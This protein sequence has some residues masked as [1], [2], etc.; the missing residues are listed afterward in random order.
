MVTGIGEIAV[1][2]LIAAVLV[3][4]AKLLKQPT[5]LA[6]LVAGVVIGIFGFFHFDRGDI[7]NVFSDLGIMFLLFLVGLEINYTSL[8][9][10]GKTSLII[11]LGQI[12]FTSFFGFIISRVLG[13][14]G[15]E[16][17]YIAIG[18][19]FSSTIIII[20]LLSA[21]DALNSLYGKISIG[22]LLVQDFVAIII[23][24]TLAGIQMGEGINFV[25]ILITVV[26]GMI[27]FVIML[28]LGRKVIPY[29][30]NKIAHSQELLFLSSL[31]WLFSIA[32]IVEQAGFSIEIGGFLAGLALANSSERFEISS[33]MR[34]LRDFFLLIFFVILGS[35]MAFSQIGGLLVPIIIL[36]LFVL[37]GNPIIVIILM[38][39]MGYE[40][41]VSFMAGVTVAQISEFSLIIAAMGFRLGHIGEGTVS[42]IT[43]VGVVTITTST[44]LIIHADKIF[45]K[46]SPYLKFFDRIKKREIHLP[47]D[48]LDKPIVLFGYHRTGQ[49]L[50]SHIPKEDL[51]VI[52]FD[53][54]VIKHLKDSGYVS[55]FG[56]ITDFDIFEKVNLKKARLV[57][58]TSP[59]LENNLNLLHQLGKGSPSKQAPKVIVR[60]DNEKEARILYKAGADYVLMPH[61]ISGHYLSSIITGDPELKTLKALKRRD[62]K[63]MDKDRLWA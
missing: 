13:F 51:L 27:L 28:A 54:T 42:V 29:I 47:V 52:D 46:I 61:F 37:I 25:G 55:V 36:S 48:N 59:R 7:F 62:I 58:S 20:Q 32:A 60:S 14:A 3:V 26:E 15:I 57:I 50:A 63:M 11:G 4:I 12:I 38:G 53:P 10:V 39:L 16:A 56:D 1:V 24:I 5:I 30:F 6:Y 43:A 21:K 33:R 34:P 44:Y 40:K 22:F 2:M 31:A 35:S 18:L 9:L 23:L 17:L 8:R 41:R 19:T 49:S 45:R